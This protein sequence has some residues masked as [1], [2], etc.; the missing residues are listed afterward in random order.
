M[1]LLN[2]YHTHLQE[3]Q[4]KIV[5]RC[6]FLN[7]TNILDKLYYNITSLFK[8][9]SFHCQIHVICSHK[10]FCTH[11]NLKSDGFVGAEYRNENFV[12]KCSLSCTANV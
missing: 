6:H 7:K 5:D 12:T 3:T 1:S 2:H 11:H 9:K 10:C 8:K 4:I